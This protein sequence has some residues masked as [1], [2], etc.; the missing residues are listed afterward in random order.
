MRLYDEDIGAC[1]A[2]LADR[3]MAQSIALAVIRDG[4]YIAEA[5]RREDHVARDHQLAS[6]VDQEA[7]VDDREVDG[8]LD[9]HKPS[10]NANT[11]RD[12]WEDEEMLAKVAALYNEDPST[13]GAVSCVD[14]DLD[15]G[16]DDNSYIETSA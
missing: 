2:T 11:R 7:I 12:P 1:Q 6:R 8:L 4:S 16:P 14:N 9:H 13:L 10:H 15:H 5:H 3:E